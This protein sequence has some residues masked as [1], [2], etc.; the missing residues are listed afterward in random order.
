[1]AKAKKGRYIVRVTVTTSE[2]VTKAAVKESVQHAL[3]SVVRTTLKGKRGSAL[4][5]EVTA[6]TASAIDEQ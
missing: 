5:V 3:D 2:P 4:A 1:M 6:A